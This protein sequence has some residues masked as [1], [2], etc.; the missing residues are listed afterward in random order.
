MIL[1]T[2]DTKISAFLFVL[3][4]LVYANTLKHDYA[5]DDSI[6]ITENARVKKGISNIA[7]LFVKYNSDYKSDKYGYRPITLSSFALDVTLFG[8]KP[9]GGHLMN[10]LY[11]SL[12]CMVLYKMLRRIFYH[13][14]SLAPLLITLVFLVHPAHT[15]VVANI[16]SRDEMFALLFG[17]LSL[18]QFIH[19]AQ[20]KKWKFL[21]YG[22][23]FFLIAFLSKEN[24][25]AF[26]GIIPLTLFYMDEK[27]D[28]K[29]LLFPLAALVLLGMV[30]LLI[31]NLYTGSN[32]GKSFSEGAG[33]Y[34]E[35]GILGN[36]FLYSGNWGEKFANAFCVLA[37]YAKHFFIPLRQLYYYGYN[38]IPVAH[39]TDLLVVIS[40]LV[41]LAAL[42]FAVIRFKKYREISYGI[43][44]YFISIFIYTHL[45]RAL[46][47]TMADRFLF[48]PSLG[49]A[50]VAVFLL[51]YVFK[52]DSKTCS[53]REWLVSKSRGASALKYSMLVVLVL[54]TIKTLS[55][56][57]DWKNNETLITHDMPY[58]ENCSRAHQYYADILK[59]KLSSSYNASM[60]ASMIAHYTRSFEISEEAYYARLGLGRY[61]CSKKNY[62]EGI[63]VLEKMVKL[64]P[65]QADPNFYLGEALFHTQRY[66]EAILYLDKS[67]LL[68][69]AILSTYYFLALA[70]S[71]SGAMEQAVST[72]GLA[73]Q[74]FGE[75]ALIYDALGNI[76]FD[77][78]D[79]DQSTRYTFEQLRF[80]EDPQKVYGIVIGRYQFLK[81]DKAAA[82]YYEQAV[83]KGI[84]KRP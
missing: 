13:Y 68:A 76:Y 55:R 46:A 54:L 40:A 48:T 71:K 58:L 67:R 6:V 79:M 18:N 44:F 50:I 59:E 28:Y 60:E 51:L 39:C 14:S 33:I 16:K 12:L 52:V 15:E 7:D 56:N 77:A 3:A 24:A 25:I 84:F 66:K 35:S 53:L 65:Q 11:F 63:P 17:L 74:K 73:K 20:Q 80:G 38:Q 34:H 57:A 2:P 27:A 8:A 69:P 72:I 1:K 37:F 29:K 10:V 26:L 42:L 64:F 19:Y 47:D 36:S 78:G 62:K 23:V 75:S 31:V 61:Y 49:L 70:Y 41:H 45:L 4:F 9:F 21:L 5:W 30:S 32:L 83:A 81:S 22:S 43:L 82:F